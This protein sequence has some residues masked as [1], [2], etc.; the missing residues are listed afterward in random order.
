MDDLVGI[1]KAVEGFERLTRESREVLQAY[2]H[3]IMEAKGK[4]RA[5]VIRYKHQKRVID[6][7]IETQRLVS[8]SGLTY[9]PPTEKIAHAIL[10]S[11]SREADPTMS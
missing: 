3:P 9:H 8:Q 4:A 7:M 11:A 5:E 2:F 6:L 10:D 1:G